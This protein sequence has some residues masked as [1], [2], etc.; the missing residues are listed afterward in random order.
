MGGGEDESGSSMNKGSG[1][2]QRFISLDIARGLAALSVLLSHW[3]GWTG[4]YAG[5][6]SKN[7]I[8]AFLGL[9]EYINCESE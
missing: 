8:D 5:P 7:V 4:T 6:A 1:K 3:G 2:I 9:F